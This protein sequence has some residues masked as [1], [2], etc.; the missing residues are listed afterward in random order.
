MEIYGLDI[1]MSSTVNSWI[2]YQNKLGVYSVLRVEMVELILYFM[3][4]VYVRLSG[5]V[6]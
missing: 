4:S 6:K 2:V 5:L 1:Q 3:L